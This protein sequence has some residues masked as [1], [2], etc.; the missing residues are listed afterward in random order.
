MKGSRRLCAAAA[1][2][3]ICAGGVPAGAEKGG[4]EA[5]APRTVEE[6]RTGLCAAAQEL[7]LTQVILRTASAE[8]GE[9]PSLEWFETRGLELGENSVRYP[10]LREGILPAELTEKI[11]ERMLEDGEIREYVS[12]MSQL[13]SGGRLEV[14]WRG[15]VMGPVFSF[16]ISAEGALK[17]PRE[18]H[19]RL[20]G[21]LDLRDGH[22]IVPEEI[23]TDPEEAR[24]RIEQYL[25]ENL[26]P[27]LSA[28]LL[29]SSLVPLPERF[30][31]TERGLILLYEIDQLSTLSDRAG[32]VLIPWNAVQD[33]LNRNGD[34]IPEAL[35]LFLREAWTEETEE[36]SEDQLQAI[37]EAA[38]EGCFPGIPAKLGDP[39]QALTEEWH[40]LTDPDVYALGRFFSLEGAPFQQVFLMTD[41]LSEGWEN[42]VV[43][44]IRADSGS[45]YGLSIGGTKQEVW[46][47]FLGEPDHTIEFDEEQAE[48]YRTVPGSRDYY[49]AGEHRLQLHADREGMLTSII[50]SE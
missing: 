45:L 18:T 12:R 13:I 33:S 40:L 10:A 1:A 4:G 17:T 49:E 3:L 50:L 5:A 31:L 38:A 39:L 6:R 30:R 7:G 14:S 21:N 35:G 34:G 19:R 25:E 27:E 46:R 24:G 41:F 20:S 9:I 28:H 26:A 37:R 29:N 15:C 36:I 16:E 11:N 22:E 42:S 47:R 43:D 44:G 2:L 48:A 23:W 8:E 32:D